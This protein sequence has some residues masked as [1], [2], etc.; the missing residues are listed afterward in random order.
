MWTCRR[1]CGAV[2]LALLAGPPRAVPGPDC[3][4]V[5][6]GCPGPGLREDVSGGGCRRRLRMIFGGRRYLANLV[7]AWA[8][9]GR[10]SGASVPLGARP[11]SPIGY[12]TGV[13]WGGPRTIFGPS[14]LGVVASKSGPQPTSSTRSVSVTAPSVQPHTV[15][16]STR[17]L[18]T[19]SAVRASRS[20]SSRSQ[21]RSASAA[22]RICSCSSWSRSVPNRSSRFM[23]RRYAADRLDVICVTRRACTRPQ[24]R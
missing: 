11:G 12:G 17:S 22:V 4:P 18:A 9:R 23:R 1:A 2:A 20:D 5:P 10:R 3:S 15:R 6:G 14:A 16:R 24:T 7:R 19:R 13:R 21:N 8:G